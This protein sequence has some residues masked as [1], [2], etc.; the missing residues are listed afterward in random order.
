[1]LKFAHFQPT[2]QSVNVYSYAEPWFHLCYPNI[3]ASIIYSV[4]IFQILFFLIFFALSY[5]NS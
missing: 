3:K 1:M 2:S 5:S 4:V